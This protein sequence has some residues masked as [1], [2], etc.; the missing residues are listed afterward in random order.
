MCTEL[1]ILFARGLYWS[2]IE[3]RYPSGEVQ[4][5]HCILKTAVHFPFC[6]CYP[7]PFISGDWGVGPPEFR[8]SCHSLTTEYFLSCLLCKSTMERESICIINT[9]WG[10]WYIAMPKHS[11]WMIA[12]CITHRASYTALHNAVP[13]TL[14][15]TLES[16]ITHGGLCCNAGKLF[17]E[18]STCFGVPQ[19][20]CV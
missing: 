10:W 12:A 5:F 18:P 19:L 17:F 1:E 6:L 7:F 14:F 20:A 16:A 2:K 4:H 9:V 15:Q 11:L 3:L 8:N 13:A